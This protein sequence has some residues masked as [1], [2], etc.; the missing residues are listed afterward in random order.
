M[1]C[2]LDTVTFI[3]TFKEHNTYSYLKMCVGVVCIKYAYIFYMV[4]IQVCE[5]W[6]ND[7]RHLKWRCCLVSLY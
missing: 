6:D 7:I 4:Y 1:L 3:E 2:T 5:I